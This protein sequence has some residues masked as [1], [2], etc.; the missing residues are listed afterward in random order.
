MKRLRWDAPSDQRPL[1][2]HPYRDTA[3]VYGVMSV[4]VVVLAVLTGGDVSNAIVVAGLFFLAATL[5]TW[6]HWRNRLRVRRMQDRE[7]LL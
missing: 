6:R 4:I 3:L 1:P 5:W 2:K 7:Q